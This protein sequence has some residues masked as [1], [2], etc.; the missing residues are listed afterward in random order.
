MAWRLLALLALAELLGM[1][2]WFTGVAVAPQLDARWGLSPEQVGGLSTPVQLGF[3]TGT[4]LVAL[5]N[6]ADLIPAKRFFATPDAAVEAFVA[7]EI[8]ACVLE[9][10]PGSLYASAR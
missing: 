10:M 3:V 5:L 6:L 2:T 8:V 9:N 4:A 1:S 7:A